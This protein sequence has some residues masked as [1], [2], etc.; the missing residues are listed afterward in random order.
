LTSVI[1]IGSGAAGL[2]AA[3]SARES[4]AEVTVLEATPT[5]GGTTAL[6]S[7]AAWLPN[8]HLA[9]A[10]SPD[11]ARTYLRSLG[12]TDADTAA[13]DRFVDDAPHVARWLETSTPLRWTALP[14]PDCHGAL[15][16]AFTTGGRSL[17]PR[18]FRPAVK[19]AALMRAAPP[20]RP[21]ST[22]T[23]RLT[24]QVSLDTL[25]QR[26]RA[27]ARPAGQA[28]VAALLTAALDAGITIRTNARATRFLGTG[29]E[30]DGTPLAGRVVLAAGGFERDEPLVR[31]FLGGPV[32][33]LVG[34]PGARGDGLRMAIA[35]GAALRNTSQAWWC[36]TI[37]IPGDAPD[38]EPEYRVLLA[39][40]ARP[41]AVLVDGE[42][43]RFTNE[44]QSYHEVGRALRG[45]GP[46]WLVIDATYRRSYP[47]GPVQP[48]DP[49]PA[50]LRRGDTLTE[51]AR[52]MDL[53]GDALTKTINR[54][55]ETA[56]DGRDPDF[57]R[58][59]NAYDR[60]MGGHPPLGPLREPPFHAVPVHLGVGGTSGGPRTDPDGRV[61]S[62][63]GTAV[64]GLY[65]AGN[66][67]ASP[68]G[69]AYPGTGTTIGQALV[70]GARA[71]RAAAE[72]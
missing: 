41:G 19:V 71:G 15:P 21:L 48:G 30:V 63:D 50:W 38:G 20:G 49:E 34:A 40:R 27:G 18:P 6:S 39:E 46:T 16:G 66:V 13:L 56:G 26:R 61:L 29:V 9:G 51:L 35:A 3:L 37:R 55:N 32:P 62:D 1:V 4:G 44:A 36:P 11:L 25:E 12:G 5:I 8:N 33:G 65:A 59:A 52:L 72:D 60:V 2:A 23:E 45:S 47:I 24:G 14:I 22:L 42:G 70:F 58:G 54:F 43:H 17:E 28:L 10:D 68:F 31:R 69:G 64:A 67:A 7:G 57:D 53:P